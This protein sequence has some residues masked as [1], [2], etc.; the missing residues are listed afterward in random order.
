MSP[1]EQACSGQGLIISISL[2]CDDLNKQ[3]PTAWVKPP[4]KVAGMTARTISRFWTKVQIGAADECWMWL[5]AKVPNGYGV[6][7]VGIGA[8]RPGNKEYAHRVSYCLE[9]KA[10]P[11][12]GQVVMHSC[13]NRG[14]VNPAHL[15]LGT[16]RENLK[17]AVKRG[18]H[19]GPV[20]VFDD[21]EHMA[22]AKYDAR[23]S[24][25]GRA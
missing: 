15:S 17:Q 10:W 19:M 1:Q 8:K 16:Q 12:K 11:P 18:R 5:A 20:R 23:Y 14:C 3:S 13:D 6:V 21:P 2:T 9:H 24:D 7:W 22:N 25:H 4:R